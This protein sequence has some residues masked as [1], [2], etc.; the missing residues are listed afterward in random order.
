VRGDFIVCRTGGFAGFLIRLGT[1]SRWNH[2]A[3]V[4]DDVGIIEATPQGVMPGWVGE[5]PKR[6]VSRATLTPLQRE[7]IVAY[8]RGKQGVGY[9]WFDIAALALVAVGVR[10]R[11]LDDYA[12][13][14]DRLVCSQLVAYAYDAAGIRLG[15]KDPW[16]VTPGDLA[17]FITEGN[18]E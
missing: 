6:A 16:T 18:Y 17:E 9:G 12:R 2:A 13:R 7:A 3:V 4:T 15:G 14:D 11:W 1:F 8:C 5:Y 10:P